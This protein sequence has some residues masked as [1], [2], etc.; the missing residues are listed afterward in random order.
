MDKAKAACG[1]GG[2]VAAFTAAIAAMIAAFNAPGPDAW[3]MFAM[4]A[5]LANNIPVLEHILGGDMFSWPAQL[6][7]MEERVDGDD[8][9]RLQEYMANVKETLHYRIRA[10]ARHV[11]DYVVR[12]RATLTAALQTYPEGVQFAASKAI[13]HYNPQMLHDVLNSIDSEC[14][15]DLGTHGAFYNRIVSAINAMQRSDTSGEHRTAIREM[16]NIVREFFEVQ[17]PMRRISP[18][19]FTHCTHP[20]LNL[21]QLK[22]L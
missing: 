3:P 9:R 16:S 6:S 10:M 4:L 2:T 14:T 17:N 13:E 20:N 11:A 7:Q 5:F 15:L 8:A 22:R 18:K 19:T 21:K 12:H 1:E